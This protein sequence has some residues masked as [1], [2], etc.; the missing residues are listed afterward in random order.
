VRLLS[1]HRSKRPS[2]AGFDEPEGG[3][4][5]VTI[6][7]I[8]G[9]FGASGVFG[10]LQDGLNTIWGVKP[11]PGGGIWGFVRTRFLSFAMVGGVCFLFLVSLT[12]ETV[13]RG[14]SA[15]LKNQACHRSRGVGVQLCVET[16]RQSLPNKTLELR[17]ARIT[18]TRRSTDWRG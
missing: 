15:Y 9:L 8:V 18:G 6:G 2:D 3:I 7:I 17:I 4:L 11:K 10:Q 1:R 14:F 12:V 16:P 13:L 5:A